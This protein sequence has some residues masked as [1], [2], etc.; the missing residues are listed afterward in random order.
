[1]TCIVTSCCSELDAVKQ[2]CRPKRPLY[3]LQQASRGSWHVQ[4]PKPEIGLK[5]HSVT[6]AGQDPEVRAHLWSAGAS[7]QVKQAA[8]FAP[9]TLDIRR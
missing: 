7:A 5:L 3:T 1:M 2:K 9:E 4:L 6:G 8:M